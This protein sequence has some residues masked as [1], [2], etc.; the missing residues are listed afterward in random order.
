MYKNNI[1]APEMAKKLNMHPTTLRKRLKGTLEFTVTE[2]KQ[3]A[4]MFNLTI[5]D[6]FFSG[7][8]AQQKNVKS[9]KTG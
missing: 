5:E 8:P 3:I 4:D 7:E 1:S 9:Q 6:L 2:A